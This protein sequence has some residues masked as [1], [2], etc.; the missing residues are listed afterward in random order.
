[1][2]PRLGDHQSRA[3]RNTHRA[4]PPAAIR[5]VAGYGARGAAGHEPAS[6]IVCASSTA[7][8]LG[9]G[10]SPVRTAQS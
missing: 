3:A 1:M 7:D 5:P 6:R 9:G 8:Q 2:K 4:K 10:K